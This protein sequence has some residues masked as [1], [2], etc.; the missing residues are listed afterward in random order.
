MDG[1]VQR[2][3]GYIEGTLKEFGKKLESISKGQERIWKA[4]DDM[5]KEKAEEIAEIQ[6][7]IAKMENQKVGWRD[8]SGA[9][10]TAIAALSSAMAVLTV[11][12]GIK[13]GI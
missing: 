4:I 5:K 7:K 2:S 13:G 8:L 10:K 12:L 11:I 3:L 6:I 9:V 1:D